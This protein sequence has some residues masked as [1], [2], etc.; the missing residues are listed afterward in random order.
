MLNI[1]QPATNCDPTVRHGVAHLELELFS[2]ALVFHI[3]IYIHMTVHVLC[4]HVSVHVS[5][6]Y[7]WAGECAV[8]YIRTRVNTYVCVCAKE[9]GPRSCTSETK[10]NIYIQ[11]R[12]ETV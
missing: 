7:V 6:A 4:M 10:T 2:I 12:N 8:I 9:D 5:P 1:F 3:Y 11:L